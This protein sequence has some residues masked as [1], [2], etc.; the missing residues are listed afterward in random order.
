MGAGMEGLESHLRKT[1]E[2]KA[3]RG[4]GG[5]FPP[6]RDGEWGRK[7]PLARLGE[8]IQ[9]PSDAV[10]RILFQERYA[11]FGSQ[12][13]E[14]MDYRLLSALYQPIVA[15]GSC[16]IHGYAATVRGPSDSPL[17][18]PHNL[19]ALAELFGLQFELECMGWQ[20][21]VENFVRLNLGGDLYLRVMGESRESCDLAAV[22]AA[23]GLDVSRVVLELA[24]VAQVERY[25]SQ[26]FRVGVSELGGKLENPDSWQELRADV[27]IIDRHFVEGAYQDP[28]KQQYLREIRA[29][30]AEAGCQII[31]EGVESQACLTVLKELGIDY[32]LGPFISR[33]SAAPSPVLSAE[34]IK[35]LGQGG[36]VADISAPTA[37]RLLIEVAPVAPDLSM[38]AVYEVFAANPQLAAVP[39]VKNGV[40]IGLINRYTLIDRYARPYHR[41]LYG[42][43]HCTHFMDPS[44]LVVDKGISIEELSNL[45]VEAEQRYLSDGFIITDQGRYAGMGT[46]HALMREIT[47]LRIRAARYANPL[48]GLPGNVPINEHIDSLLHAD[49]AFFACYADL[50]HFKPFNDVYGYNRGDD[51]IQLTGRLLARAAD[52]E[53]DF[54]GHVGGDD[55]VVLFQSADWERRCRDVLEGFEEEV[56]RF[57]NVED[58]ERG[59]Y[60]AEDR[61]GQKIFHPLASLAIGAVRIEPN[62]FHSHR[63]VAAAAAEA[64]KQAKRTP[65]NNLFIERRSYG[66]K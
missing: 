10:S 63:E 65:G 49:A 44:P 45:V 24:S 52:P 55:F 38:E 25:R 56:K 23:N 15:L 30:T 36:G 42:K 34:V 62:A 9:A 46:G 57:F 47:Q 32:A 60:I 8:C 48:T 31:A 29:L 66:A 39:V 13:R 40:P 43:R 2:D 22:V 6:V 17:H 54:V 18:V 51:V 50:N 33:P 41:D 12:L 27:G 35:A 61:R 19:Y 37:E 28:L 21:L 58:V 26:G 3:P 16:D 11:R 20:V 7:R 14:V 1:L 53:R 59:G 4:E 64:K 5:M